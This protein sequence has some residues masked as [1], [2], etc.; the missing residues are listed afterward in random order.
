MEP[1]VTNQEDCGSSRKKPTKKAATLHLCTTSET[2]EVPGLEPAAASEPFTR[3]EQA[4][5]LVWLQKGAS[6]AA[7]CAQLGRP[8]EK[9]WTTLQHDREFSDTFQRLYDTLSQNVLSALYQS[10]MKGSVTAQQFWLRQR[11][12]TQ[13]T[14][15]HDDDEPI[16]TLRG[17][18]DN[19]LVDACR[20]AGL[21]LPA[22]L[23]SR[24]GA[25]MRGA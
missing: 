5:L 24:M 21:D 10:A 3:A 4:E 9:F 14:T 17:L 23:T 22:D 15:A 20:T 7:A 11:P 25:P 19:Q 16:H 2:T 13:W 1:A 8:V 12:A 18:N 6:P